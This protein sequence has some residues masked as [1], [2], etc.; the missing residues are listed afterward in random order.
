MKS[1]IVNGVILPSQDVV[2]SLLTYKRRTVEKTTRWDKCSLDHK[3]KDSDPC[4]MK[5]FKKLHLDYHSLRQLS[6]ST[7]PKGLSNSFLHRPIA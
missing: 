6:I 3:V 1:A 5:K 7:D 2:N 4:F